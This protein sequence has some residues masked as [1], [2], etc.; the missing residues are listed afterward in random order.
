M[1]KRKAPYTKQALYKAAKS[2]LDDGQL[3]NSASLAAKLRASFPEE[4]EKDRQ[5]LM[6]IGLRV[7]AGR[8][9]TMR[10]S[11]NSIPDLFEKAQ[12]VEFYPIRT[13]RNNKIV[14]TCVPSRRLTPR[15][16]DEQPE[17]KRNSKTKDN[18]ILKYISEM[19]RKGLMDTPLEDYLNQ[20]P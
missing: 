12:L 20:E 9:T 3:V 19:R 4:I 2:L 8:I 14:R 17:I 7:L 16:L 10:G 18:P 15:M 1:A 13:L 11:D 5:D 6:D